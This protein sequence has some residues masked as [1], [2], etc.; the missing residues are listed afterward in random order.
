MDRL[1]KP[2]K[3]SADLNSPL[4]DKQYKHWLKTFQNFV[5]SVRNAD[6]EV[7][8]LA[9]LVN[10][11][12]PT[13]YCS[14]ESATTYDDA[15]SILKSIYIK[16]K[17]EVFAR[18]LLAIRSQHS[19]DSIKEYFRELCELAKDCNFKDVSAD[20]NRNQAIRD[21]FIGGLDS[22]FIRQCLLEN[23]TLDLK[24]AYDQ[25]RTLG[26]TQRNSESYTQ[27][28]MAAS[29]NV[30]AD[31]RSTVASTP[32]VAYETAQDKTEVALSSFA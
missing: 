32:Q 15:L 13:A 14:I 3:L 20:E 19:D 7:D 30:A 12:S 25:A 16:P 5:E 8:K 29:A 28:R 21:S 4:A 2:E 26:S 17:N 24:T 10:Y 6:R 27:P 1:L 18:H 9:L 22:G 23:Q 11:V 31:D